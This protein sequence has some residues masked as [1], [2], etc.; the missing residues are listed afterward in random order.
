[1]SK[2]PK[3]A[4]RRSVSIPLLA[5][6]GGIVLI[7]AGMLFTLQGT[8]GSEGDGVPDIAISPATID[9][10][11]IKLDTPLTFQIEVANQGGE[12]LRIEGEPY[13]EVLEGC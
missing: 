8:G 5:L 12:T 7:V 4:K 1:M 13:L 10:G 9:Y 3:K 2:T 11:D 6:A